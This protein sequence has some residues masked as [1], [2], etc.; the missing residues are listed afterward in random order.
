MPKNSTL[1]KISKCDK[2]NMNL[3]LLWLHTQRNDFSS[4]ESKNQIYCKSE[5]L[6]TGQKLVGWQIR[7]LSFVTRRKICPF[8]TSKIIHKR[9]YPRK[10]ST[11]TFSH[12]FKRLTFHYYH[13]WYVMIGE[14][15]SHIRSRNTRFIFD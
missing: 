5:I 10:L 4:C 2:P 12:R 7:L 11:I 1:F 8:F 13:I 6:G 9:A 15:V 3:D 14:V